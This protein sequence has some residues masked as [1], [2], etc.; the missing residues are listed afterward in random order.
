MKS[1]L[2][3]RNRL[4]LILAVFM[5]CVVVALLSLYLVNRITQTAPVIQNIDIDS[6]TLVSLGVMHQTSTR[7]GIK[8]WSLEAASARIL[9]Q[10]H[11]AVLTDV[12]VHFFLTGGDEIH[13]TSRAG[14]L[15]T[16][17]HD[18]TF[19][20]TVVVRHQDQVLKTDRLQYEKKRHIIYSLN[21]VVLTS[22]RAEMT[23]NELTLDLNTH[24][25]RLTGDFKGFFLPVAEDSF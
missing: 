21:P 2:Q 16:E 20:D 18:M 14:T 22:P 1:G 5:A 23:A 11:L 17:K 9:K 3:G 25:V 12:S 24:V 10:E 6:K 13:L 8:E 4:L 15:D 19:S 7:N